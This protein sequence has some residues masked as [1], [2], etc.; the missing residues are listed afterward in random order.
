MDFIG[1]PTLCNLGRLLDA[2]FNIDLLT[3][4]QGVFYPQ[5]R[6]DLEPIYL[7]LDSSWAD[8]SSSLFRCYL[9]L[10]TMGDQVPF[11]DEEAFVSKLKRLLEDK[12]AP[13]VEDYALSRL[14]SRCQCELI[15]SSG[16][17]GFKFAGLLIIS[18]GI[19]KFDS[20]IE[21]EEWREFGP[22]FAGRGPVQFQRLTF[23]F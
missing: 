11:S 20:E 7:A 14:Q 1:A 18:C 13:G 6:D 15:I 9:P 3:A 5:S 19:S 10:T 4:T 16:D 22:F 8:R 21:Q 17:D 23:K 2:D 12:S